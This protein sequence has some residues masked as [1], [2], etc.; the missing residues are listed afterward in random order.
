LVLEPELSIVVFRRIGWTDEQ[1]HAWS[2]RLLAAEDG[3]V[4]PSAWRGETVLRYCIVNPLTT[5]D[6]IAFILETLA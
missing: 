3:F 2:A 6:D 5:V 4:V 1:Y